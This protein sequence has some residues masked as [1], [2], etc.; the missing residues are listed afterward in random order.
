MI[1]LHIVLYVELLGYFD[2]ISFIVKSWLTAGFG[3][4]SSAFAYCEGY[5]RLKI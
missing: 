1:F 4:V 5:Q 2:L 3:N